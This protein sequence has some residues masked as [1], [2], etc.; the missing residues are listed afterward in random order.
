MINWILNLIGI[1][2]YFIGRYSNRKNK[3]LKGTFSFW[4]K[5][6]W[7]ELSQTLLLNVALMII[8]QMKA[9]NVNLDTFFAE[10]IPY[11]TIDPTVGKAII[12]LSLGLGI[13]ALIYSMFRKKIK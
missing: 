7:P 3:T 10:K 5:D 4:I 11:I 2:S 13:T 1:V 6:N 9:V 12:A 8:L